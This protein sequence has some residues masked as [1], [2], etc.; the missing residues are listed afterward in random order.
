MWLV[1][2]CLPRICVNL[3]SPKTVCHFAKVFLKISLVSTVDFIWR[4][5]AEGQ[6]EQLSED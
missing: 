3:K 4:I 2:L 1:T 5:Y 6:A